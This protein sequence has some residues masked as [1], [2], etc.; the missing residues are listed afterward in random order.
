VRR[1]GLLGAS[2]AL[3]A[4]ALAQP[5]TAQTISGRAF[6]DRDADGILDPG[7]PLLSGVAFRLW[8]TRSGG[9]ALD[10]IA[11]TDANGAFAISAGNGC[12]L[13]APADPPGWR[14]SQARDDGFPQST[15][16]YTQPVGRPRLAKLDQGIA[17]LTAG[18]V[19]LAAMGDSIARSFNLCQFPEAFWYSKQV[20]SR[21]AC[22]A[23]SATITL[24]QAAVLGEH[25]DDL[26]VDDQDN[27]N[28][29]YRIVE[30]QPEIITL[31]MIGNDLL[32]VD[33]GGAPTQA[34]INRAVAE[35]LDARRNLQEAL[36]VLTSEVPGADIVLNTLYDNEAW[37]CA[38]GDPSAFHRSWLPIVNR[39]LKE[40]AWGQARRASITEAAADFAHENQTRTC[41]GFTGLICRDLFGLDRIHPTLNGYAVVRE[42]LWEASGG[43][44]LGTQDPLGRTSLPGA[45]YGFLRRVRRVLPTRWEVRGGAAVT[46]PGAA[47]DEADAG[48]AA[49]ITLGAGSEEFR[50]SGFPD[51]YDEVQ[52][53]KVV[54]GVRYRTTG[55]VNDDAYRMEASPTGAF[56]PPPGHAYTTTSWNFYTPL[57]GGGGPNQPPE[58]PDYPETRVLAVPDVASYREVT[59]T[60]TRDPVLPPGA[61]D[62]AWPP[63]THEELATAA[64]RV[65][66]APVAATPGNDPYAVELDAGWLDLYGWEKPRPAEVTGLQV[67]PD[68]GGGLRITFDAAPGAQRYNLYAGRLPTLA[69]GAYDHGTG[70]PAGPFCDVATAAAGPGRI[71][72]ILGAASVPAGSVYLLVT[73]HMDGVESPAGY[74]SD[75][76]EIDRSGSICR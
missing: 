55:S 31:S 46:S 63:V 67:E 21:F 44:L 5:A 19:R 39:I 1:P 59:A 33:P 48:A 10:A 72:T 27:L 9:G 8:G 45:D 75:G 64:I 20:Q 43:V 41:L 70:A 25:T 13:L 61:A 34:Q 28:N 18:Q 68:T 2:C 6:E 58:N 76:G 56:R 74:R 32:D 16:G 71:E 73:A 26:L 36:S 3:A 17:N 69:A 65:A 22:A 35:I 47:L 40:L 62:Y 52:I 30:V 54:A 12:Y 23:P 24:D 53:V 49:R 42:K 7:E 37:N 14:M 38:T 60:L 4:A 15:P 50:L 57:V 29:V 11:P 51:W 66:A